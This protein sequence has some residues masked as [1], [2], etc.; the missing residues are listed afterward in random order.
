MGIDGSSIEFRHFDSVPLAR[1]HHYI[2]TKTSNNGKNAKIMKEWKILEQNLPDS[3]Y[4]QV[5]E[6]RIDL[7]RAVI[8]GSAATPYHDCLFFFDI[9]LPSDYPNQPPHV[10]YHSHGY[11]L[12]PNLYANGRVCLSLI[13]TWTGTKQEKWTNGSTILQLLV[14]IQGLVLNSRPYFNEPGFKKAEGSKLSM[15]LKASNRYNEDAFTLSCMTL[16]QIIQRPPQNFESFVIEHCRQRAVLLIEA[17]DNY[18]EGNVQ[19]GELGMTLSKSSSSAV[20]VSSRFKT[21]MQ[22]IRSHLELAFAPYVLIPKKIRVVTPAAAAL[23]LEARKQEKKG[24]F[25]RVA[26]FVKKIWNSKK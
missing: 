5:Y 3:I 17:I 8:V 15:W 9:F 18:E 12:N 1:D 10:Y 6:T 16:Q 21:N 20:V 26:G 24:V 23:T 4:V 19:V 25:K 22:R 7:L 14:S 11:R 2:N 13:N